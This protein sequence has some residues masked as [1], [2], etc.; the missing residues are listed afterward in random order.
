MP[1]RARLDRERLHQPC[2]GVNFEQDL[3]Q[4]LQHD[5][6]FEH[7]DLLSAGHQ[8]CVH[9]PLDIVASILEGGRKTSHAVALAI[10]FEVLVLG[11]PGKGDEQGRR[12]PIRFLTRPNTQLDISRLVA[13]GL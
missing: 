9:S 3:P 2:L 1:G 12:Y 7:W 5:F 10:N 8:P 6:G 13:M 4:F 11:T